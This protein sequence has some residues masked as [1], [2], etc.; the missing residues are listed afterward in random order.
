MRHSTCIIE[1]GA[2]AAATAELGCFVQVCAGASIGDQ[3]VIE[4]LT[5]VPPNV[6]VC[7]GARVG[8]G[9]IFVGP[10][11]ADV[12]HGHGRVYNPETFRRDFAQAGLTI[13]IFGGCWLKPVSN[14]Q[15]E[16]DWTPE[17]LEGF[18][19]IGGALP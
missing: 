14:S 12:H 15:I 13:E 10:V 1:P 4:G 5:I 7:E 2:D 16:R 8:H 6:Q 17:M 18:N 19:A 9:V 11:E 3:S